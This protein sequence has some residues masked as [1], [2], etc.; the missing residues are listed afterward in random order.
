MLSTEVKILSDGNMKMD[1]GSMF[2]SMPKLSWENTVPTD[3]K[4]RI[5]LGLNCLLLQIGGKNILVDTGIGPKDHEKNKEAL[6][7]VP[8][9]LLKGLR[10]LGIRPKDINKVV[11]TDLQF[12]HSGGVLGWIELGIWWLHSRKLNIMCKGNVGIQQV[13]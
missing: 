4:N 9:R 8:S 11:L 12:D 10:N 5:T 7:L 6:G 3:R 2:G 1:G 13:I